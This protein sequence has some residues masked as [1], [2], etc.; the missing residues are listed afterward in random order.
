MLRNTGP[1]GPSASCRK[2]GLQGKFHLGH[3]GCT[4][5]LVV[6]GAL[7]CDEIARFDNSD[8]SAF[9]GNIV[10]GI[11]VREGFD[12]QARLQLQLDTASLDRFPGKITSDDGATMPCGDE[13]LFDD[14]K[15]RIS[16]KLQADPLST[17]AFGESREL[18][19]LTWVDSSCDG[20][21][22]AVISLMR[23]SEVEVRLMRSR[24][25]D[26]GEEQGP[27]GVFRLRKN[28]EECGY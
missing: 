16:E 12:R 18:N 27:F 13:R 22:L 2:R 11:F 14:A 7:G 4:L 8:G 9:C 17:L 25:G 26:S 28:K 6:W 19:L 3:L 21:Y 10:G 24:A 15:L 23:N 1:A 5:A 20:T